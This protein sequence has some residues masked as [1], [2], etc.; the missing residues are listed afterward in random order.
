MRALVFFVLG[1]WFAGPAAAHEF[2]VGFT[3][4]S[5]NPDTSNLEVIHRLFADDL[6][7]AITGEPSA[8]IDAATAPEAEPDVAAYLNRTFKLA[9]AS[10]EAVTLS[11]V[12]MEANVDTV[13]AYLEAP[14]DTPPKA[15]TVTNEILFGFFGNQLNTVN[16]EVG[17]TI[18]ALSFI[19]LLRQPTTK[20]V[21]FAE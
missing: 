20:T 11:W 4:V 21:Q 15:L 8:P 5:Y 13:I 19:E 2:Y 18:R 7:Q 17:G 14:M 9:D 16:L 12:G 1:V 3:V 10:G 6:A